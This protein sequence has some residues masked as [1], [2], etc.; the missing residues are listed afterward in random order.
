MNPL[1]DDR[2]LVELKRMLEAHTVVVELT[3]RL[4]WE[5][6][7]LGE[8]Y[9]WRLSVDGELLAELEPELLGGSH[10]RN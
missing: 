3:P 9:E 4:A 2:R 7:D 8:G 5:G 10:A 1:L 6:Y